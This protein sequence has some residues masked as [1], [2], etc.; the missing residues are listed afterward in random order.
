MNYIF[1]EC[2]FISSILVALWCVR[3]FTKRW[4]NVLFYILLSS[5]ILLSVSW[6]FEAVMGIAK[7][8]YILIPYS[9]FIIISYFVY[10]LVKPKS[11]ARK[12]EDIFKLETESGTIEFYYPRDNFLVLGGAGSGK[13]ASIGKPIMK[14][15]IKFGWAGFIYDFKNYDYTQTAWN[16]MQK[17]GYPYKFY[18][19]NFT[20]MNRTYRFNIL[21]KRVI[22]TEASLLQ[23]MD[24]FLQAMK[25]KKAEENEWFQAALGLLRGIAIVFYH[26]EGDYSKYCTLP[27]ILA[28]TLMASPDELTTFLRND[29]SASMMASGFLG[30]AG[31]DKTQ[32]SIIFTLN[33]MLAGIATNK[34]ICYVLTGNDFVF[35]LVDPEDPKMFAVSNDYALQGI[36]SP[37]VAMLVPIA[38]RRIKFGNKVRFAFVLDEMTTF[39]VNDFEGMPSV[40]REFGA[41]F[42]ILTQSSTKFDKLYGKEDRSS[43]LANCANLFI[44][45]TKDPEALKVYPLL[46]GKEEKVKKSISAGSSSGRS[47]SSVT[48]SKQRE[49][50]YDSKTFVELATG[51]F[52]LSA[53]DSNVNRIKTRFKRF[54]LDEK[55]LPIVKLTVNKEID[56]NY[57]NIQLDCLKLLHDLCGR[58]V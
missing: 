39:K 52:I 18:Y 1:V 51:E 41:A 7:T 47:N 15:F 28:F 37:I 45:R 16:L 13:T 36:I 49:E 31:S 57:Q 42:L 44:G 23:A 32:S 46:F 29:T 4:K 48:T 10:G 30:S 33:N 6:F 25:S 58:G 35:D 40:L 17:Y 12:G 5:G 24:D 50:V 11:N 34:N 9:I 38:S 20:D 8:V 26:F 56:N 21:D 14:E 55:P 54:M 2:L 3:L 19:V 43:I 27:H 22:T 53:G